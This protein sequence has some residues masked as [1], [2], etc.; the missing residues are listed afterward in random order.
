VWKD[1][2]ELNWAREAWHHL[3]AQGLA[4]YENEVE[5]VAVKL[6]FLALAGFYRDFCYVAWGETSYPMYRL[7]ADEMEISQVRV[8]Q[9]VGRD[10]EANSEAD[11]GELFASALQELI[12]SARTEV[13]NALLQAY[14]G[15]SGLL[16]GLWNS[17]KTH[18]R[19]DCDFGEEGCEDCR[20]SEDEILNWCIEEKGPAYTWLDQGAE[21]LLEN[22]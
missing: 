8:G 4:Q 2:P 17:T 11:N 15:A 12:T 10:F 21:E 9:L 3:T 16:V 6:R 5:R 20:L 13:L 7:W 19:E 22:G 1:Q 14:R 18:D